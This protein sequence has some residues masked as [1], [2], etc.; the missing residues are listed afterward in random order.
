MTYADAVIA[1]FLLNFLTQLLVAYIVLTGIYLSFETRTVPEISSI[2]LAIAMAASLGLGVGTLNCFLF[3]MFPIWA[4]FWA[5]L[6]RPLFIISCTIFLYDPIP[7]PYR[8]ILWYNPLVQVVGQM[9]R[10]FYPTYDAAYVSY[11]YVFGLAVVFLAF[12]LVFLRRY[13]KELIHR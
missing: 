2:A 3:T 4:R 1:R 8:D 10:G 11:I 12:G 13:H 6:T 5:V 9:R 7:L